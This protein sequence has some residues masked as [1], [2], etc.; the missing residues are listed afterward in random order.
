MAQSGT[1][2]VPLPLLIIPPRRSRRRL[3]RVE[4][5]TRQAELRLRHL[6][7]SPTN[8]NPERKTSIGT[9]D[10]GFEFLIHAQIEMKFIKKVQKLKKEIL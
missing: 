5:S 10:L 2:T 1:S 6:I 3:K 4:A 9:A 8:T 7:L